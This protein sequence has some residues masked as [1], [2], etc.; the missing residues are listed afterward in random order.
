M[1]PGDED[2][3]E[4]IVA[5]ASED[6]QVASTIKMKLSSFLR[7]AGRKTISTALKC[8]G[9]PETLICLM[10]SPQPFAGQG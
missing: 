7:D 9:R 2:E 3:V 10:L 6:G 8:D 5:S 1:R 4:E